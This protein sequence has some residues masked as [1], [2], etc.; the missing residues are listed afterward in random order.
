[1]TKRRNKI[2]IGK[3]IFTFMFVFFLFY[4]LTIIYPFIWAFLTSIKSN[5][6]YVSDKLGLP[7]IPRFENYVKAFK[8]LE[9]GS[10]NMFMMIFNSVWFTLG[11]TTLS[12]FVSSM[13]AYVVAKYKFV[14]RNFIYGIAIF[15]MIIPIAGSLP[16]AYK[17]M[18]DLRIFDTPLMLLTFAGGFGFNFLVLYGF[19]SNLPWSYAEAGYIDGASDYKIFS[20]LMMPQ[21]YP[22][23]ASVGI[24]GS[25]GVWN[26]YLTPIIYLPNYPTL[27][28]GL[29]S[30]QVRAEY[31]MDWPMF[32]A[33]ILMSII[34]ILVVFIVFQNTIMENVVAGG[35]KE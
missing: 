31:S 24:I 33:G 29:F 8:L 22:A 3:L 4:S 13:T 34:P 19:F 14:G 25:I 17:L 6:E 18:N 23:I 9:Y 5:P 35:L 1:M 21:A 20:K 26:D 16:A 11:G 12:I 7:L 32:F 2:G 30:Y 28:S 27:A 15:I 10:T